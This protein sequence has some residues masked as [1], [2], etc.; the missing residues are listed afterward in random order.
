VE[1]LFS[2]F[3]LSVVPASGTKSKGAI[4]CIRSRSNET[5]SYIQEQL[6]PKPDA[7]TTRCTHCHTSTAR[8]GFARTLRYE[9][10]ARWCWKLRC[11][12]C[13]WESP[14]RRSTFF[15]LPLPL[16]E[17]QRGEVYQ[18]ALNF[19]VLADDMIKRL[20]LANVLEEG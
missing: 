11:F 9:E 20:E 4:E 14:L 6:F 17:K 3:V 13:A 19:T 15:P 16:H 12:S 5:S 18:F 10:T 1:K 7:L 2:P 8:T